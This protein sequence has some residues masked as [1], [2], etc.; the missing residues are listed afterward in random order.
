MKTYQ[1]VIQA[2]V[3]GV[4]GA[5]GGVSARYRECG[6]GGGLGFGFLTNP[7]TKGAPHT[8]EISHLNLP[9]APCTPSTNAC[10]ID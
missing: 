1:S 8:R 2:S 4:Q 10:I 3:G 5:G 7:K 6:S 9:P